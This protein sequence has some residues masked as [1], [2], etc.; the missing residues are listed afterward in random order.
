MAGFQYKGINQ[1]GHVIRGEMEADNEIDLEQRLKHAKVT[2]IRAKQKKVKF[3]KVLFSKKKIKR[4]DIIIMSIHM[5]K[6]LKAG[7]PLLE[8]LHDLR[9]ST[10]HPC[11]RDI[12]AEIYEDV[13][14]GQHLSQALA[15]HPQTF[16]PLYVGLVQAAEN[17]GNLNEA[18]SNLVGYMKWQDELAT[19]VKKMAIYP[20]ILLFTSIG[21]V[22][23]LM[24]KV[25]PALLEILGE[26][27]LSDNELPAATRS[28][29]AISQFFVN[30]GLQLV[31]G[32]TILFSALIIVIRRSERASFYFDVAKLKLPVFGETVRKI[33]LSRFA[34]YLGILYRS[35]IP[36][37]DALKTT[38]TV[39][40]NR[41]IAQNIDWVV[42]QVSSGTTISASL[43]A[44][45]Q[46]PALVVRMIK[47]GED[48][49]KLDSSLEEVSGFYDRE[50]RTAID[51]VISTLQP[52][53]SIVMG[54][55]VA[56][57]IAG[58]LLPYYDILGKI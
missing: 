43:T 30:Y 50:V 37:I 34:H 25:V 12:I 20:L 29:I 7:V 53:M 57:V 26:L 5:D 55:L 8:S 42:D 47:I 31:I 27:G 6:V 32:M 39:V 9:D 41:F 28:L 15:K 19:Q 33:A 10:E 4:K 51:Q 52:M 49:G 16:S 38:R 35:G 13:N 58:I 24:V 56:W 18:F 54:G 17:T 45:G 21:V 23:L 11:L 46:F 40:M 1:Q 36:V 14:N 44:T 48:T 3:A 22:I 2:L